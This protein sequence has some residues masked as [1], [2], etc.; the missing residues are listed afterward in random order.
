M[1]KTFITGM[2]SGLGLHLCRTYLE[3]GYQ[4]F[5]CDLV[6]SG[7]YEALKERYGRQVELYTG[8]DVQFTESVNKCA[9]QVGKRTDSIDVL[10]NNAG[11]IT[12]NSGMVLEEFDID[13]SYRVLNVNAL[14]P[15][16]VTK[17]FL[18]LV[19]SSEEK[20]ILNISSEAG[21]ISSHN[22]KYVSRYDYCMSKC[23]LNMQT[24]ILQR[25]LKDRGI[26]MLAV[27][28]GWMR[29]AMG[30][31]NAAVDPADSARHIFDLVQAYKGKLD[32]DIFMDYLGNHYDW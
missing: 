4:V 25:Y 15:L 5:G 22:K 31:A 28:P 9:E 1:K 11:I 24:V 14:G 13:D 2:G 12:K 17:A 6:Q 8:V 16:R 23:A 29:T 19:Q 21:S 26:K 7:E 32:G 20:V 30:G 18:P 10:I 27:F 3:A